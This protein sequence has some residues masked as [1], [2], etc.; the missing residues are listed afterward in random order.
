MQKQYLKTARPPLP[1]SSLKAAF[2]GDAVPLHNE[3]WFYHEGNRGLRQANWKIVQANA[4]REFPW[5]ASEENSKNSTSENWELY[6][7]SSD[8]AE[9]VDLAQQYPQRVRS[10]AAKWH[11]IRRQF[12]K[13]A[14]VT[15]SD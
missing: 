8:R 9:Q 3:L 14:G 6:D 4:S 10:M 15:L 12:A 11:E 7:L 2:A 5:S 13:D 1:G